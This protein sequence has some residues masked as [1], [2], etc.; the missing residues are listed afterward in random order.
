M[1]RFSMAGA[2]VLALM[3][4]ACGGGSDSPVVTDRPTQTS[5]GGAQEE[6]TEPP[7][8][9]ATTTIGTSDDSSQDAGPPDVAG[10]GAG[11]VTLEGE[12]YL[13]ADAGQPGLQCRANYLGIYF[14]VLRQVDEAGNEVPQGAVFDL[15]LLHEGT[16][17]A[18]VD[19]LPTAGL[20]IQAKDESWIADEA[21]DD[22]LPEVESGSSQVDDYTIDGNTASGTA[23][24]IE[25][26]SY[27]TAP[28]V[29]QGTF[30][31]TCNGGS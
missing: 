19:Q 9:G 16:D 8:A 11:S 10:I 29:A 1:K 26:Y 22:D 21:F 20:S 24:F 25:R 12:T 3:L 2:S 17:P 18:V 28:R 31:V 4:A 27:A 6:S 30:E 15:T 5:T 23:T 14:V 13:F 7:A